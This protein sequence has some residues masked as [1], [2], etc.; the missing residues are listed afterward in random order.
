FQTMG[1]NVIFI[2]ILNLVIGIVIP[3]IDMG[4]HIG[5]LITGFLAATITS[6]P[7]KRNYKF[8]SL[9]I[10]AYAI[11]ISILVVFGINSNENDPLYL[12]M[13]KEENNNGEKYDIAINTA[14]EGLESSSDIEASLLFQRAYDYGE[15][16]ELDLAQAD[17]EK[18]VDIETH[19]P[20]AYH[21][22]AIIYYEKDDIDQ[23]KKNIDKAMNQTSENDRFKEMYNKIM[24]SKE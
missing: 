5:G 8:S 20:E 7:K 4:A 17:L 1:K 16:N 10:V 3:N 2:L 6:L 15:L 14:S 11:I 9:A 21:N 24:E 12:I 23:A 18:R 19:F 22:L 13:T